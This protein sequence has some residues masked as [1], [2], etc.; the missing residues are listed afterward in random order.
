MINVDARK[1]M[2]DMRQALGI[3]RANMARACKCSDYLLEIMEEYGAIT[4]P[5]IASRIARRYGMDVHQYNQL[6]H[7]DRKARVLPA[8]KEPPGD[9]NFTWSRYYDEHVCRE[10]DAI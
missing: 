10:V 4:H 8:F 6:V 1:W 7:P 5:D 2:K 9:R 3:P